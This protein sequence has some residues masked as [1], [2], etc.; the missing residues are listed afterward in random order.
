MPHERGGPPGLSHAAQGADELGD[1]EGPQDRPRELLPSKSYPQEGHFVG[2]SV[3]VADELLHGALPG[4]DE[5][6]EDVADDAEDEDDRIERDDEPAHPRLLD[7][8]LKSI[9]CI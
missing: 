4:D 8:V 2:G 6:D 5:D 3:L 7:Q 9:T 1:A